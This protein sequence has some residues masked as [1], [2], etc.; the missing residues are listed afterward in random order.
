MQVRIA[1]P[2]YFQAIGIPL[3]RG[4]MFSESD[5]EGS[6]PVVLLTESAVRQ[7]FP[8]E[9]PIGRK[10]VLAMGR[11][12]GTPRAGGEIVGV[13][14]DV[15]DAGLDE[16]DPPQIYLPYRQ[17]PVQ[18]MA[19]VMK[20]SVPPASLSDAAR[21]E[22]YA[23][24]AAMPVSNMRTL[25]EV[26]ARSISQPRFYMTLL[27]VF[28][29]VALILAA[30]G[31]FGVLS[32]AV[33]QRTREI[34]IRMALGARERTVLELVV[35][36]SML[37]SMAGMALGIVCAITVSQPLISGLLFNTSPTDPGTFAAAAGLLTAVA[38]AASYIPA[39]RAT[40]VDPVIAL[41]SE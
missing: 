32:Y 27:A 17:W 24:D 1:T 39:R 14:G 21:R 33:A 5:R 38:L 28:A 7:Y 18:R 30:I 36:E 35:R 37:L 31:I 29:A 23:V 40:R 25:E 15:K 11:G 41:R 9:D 26:V 3:R 6:T 8:D 16:A 2:G 12:P 34:G 22:V 4:R 13:I 19:V 20:T 10:I